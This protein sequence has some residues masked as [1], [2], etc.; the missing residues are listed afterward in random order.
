MPYLQQNDPPVLVGL[1]YTYIPENT[2]LYQPIYTFQYF[3]EDLDGVT[4]SISSEPCHFNLAI[5][6]F[7]VTLFCLAE[8]NNNTYLNRSA[9]SVGP[10]NGTL[11]PSSNL[12][13][14]SGV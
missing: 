6:T 7:H 1:N 9:L 2:P 3:D 11:V 10:Q 13:Y 8:G 5:P 14:E 4:Y 12:N